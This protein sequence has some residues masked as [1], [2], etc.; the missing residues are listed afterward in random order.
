MRTSHF[1]LYIFSSL[2][3]RFSIRLNILRDSLNSSFPPLVFLHTD[4]H[5]R[6]EGHNWWGS[7][8]RSRS[9]PFPMYFCWHNIYPLISV[10]CT[11]IIFSILGFDYEMR[12]VG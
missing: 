4:P 5:A 1:A 9:A 10:F 6:S 7:G 2:F 3:L 8:T 11:G 12:W